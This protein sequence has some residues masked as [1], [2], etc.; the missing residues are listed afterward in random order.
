MLYT[1]SGHYCGSLITEVVLEWGSTVHYMHIPVCMY[2]FVHLCI[3]DH[4]GW[5]CLI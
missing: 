2:F 3:E 1:N 4:Y 5:A